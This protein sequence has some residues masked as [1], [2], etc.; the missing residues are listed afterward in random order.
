MRSPERFLRQS[1]AENG[2]DVDTVSVE[3]DKMTHTTKVCT[4]K[5]IGGEK[6]HHQLS[7]TEES[8]TNYSSLEQ[9]LALHAEEIARSFKETMVDILSVGERRIRVCPYD[10]G[11]VKCERCGAYTELTAPRSFVEHAE[12]GVPSPIP[13]DPEEFTSELGDWERL[14]LK[15]YL[16]GKLRTK[17]DK[18]CPNCRATNV[19]ERFKYLEPVS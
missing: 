4:A 2:V 9:L 7:L 10:G 5:E 14:V 1:I 6:Y 12:L 11:W 16:L 15:M 18:T 19:T 17:C 13:R 3:D 8:I